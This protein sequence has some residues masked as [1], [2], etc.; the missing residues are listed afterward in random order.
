MR[1]NSS[2]RTH[3]FRVALVGALG[4]AMAFAFLAIPTS[5]VHVLTLVHSADPSRT[6]AVALQTALQ[7]GGGRVVMAPLVADAVVMTSPQVPGGDSAIWE[8]LLTK[9]ASVSAYHDATQQPDYAAAREQAAEVLAYGFQRMDVALAVIP[10]ALKVIGALQALVGAAVDLDTVHEG[11]GH[12]DTVTVRGQ[13]A[14]VDMSGYA[15]HL[16][17][18]ANKPFVMVNLIQSSTT[19]EGQTAVVRYRNRFLKFAMGHGVH[20]IHGGG[21]VSLGASS[22]TQSHKFERIMLVHYPTRE[23]FIKMSRS[24]YFQHSLDDKMASVVDT[25]AFIALYTDP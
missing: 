8:F 15:A 7:R 1:S 12:I 25:Q 9:H 18:E 14:P 24:K 21:V 11:T 3:R 22:G 16:K 2:I 23:L 6:I 10:V 5:E 19:P 17:A 20:A 4:L 13:S